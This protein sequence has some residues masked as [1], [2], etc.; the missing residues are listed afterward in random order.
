MTGRHCSNAKLKMLASGDWPSTVLEAR[1][2]LDNPLAL[3]WASVGLNLMS[4]W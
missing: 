3:A 2:S 4:Y 1:G